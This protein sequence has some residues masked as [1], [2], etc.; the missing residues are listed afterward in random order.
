MITELNEGI[1]S[2]IVFIQKNLFVWRQIVLISLNILSLNLYY[3]TYCIIYS[4]KT[5]RSVK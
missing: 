2:K 5:T 3:Y 4:A 1:C